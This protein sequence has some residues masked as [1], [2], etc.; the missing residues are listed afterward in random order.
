MKGTSTWFDRVGDVRNDRK[1]D[2]FSGETVGTPEIETEQPIFDLMV[3]LPRTRP[4]CYMIRY[5]RNS[6]GDGQCLLRRNGL[7]RLVRARGE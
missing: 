2:G 3:R 5:M 7:G 6:E 1:D 4:V